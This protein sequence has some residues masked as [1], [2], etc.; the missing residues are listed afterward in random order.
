MMT[1]ILELLQELRWLLRDS[2]KYSNVSENI[3]CDSV[4]RHMTLL[5]MSGVATIT[6]S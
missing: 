1:P 2:D 4:C 5:W 6:S 3:I